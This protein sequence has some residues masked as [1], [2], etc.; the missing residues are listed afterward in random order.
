MSN[1]FSLQGRVALITGSSRGLGA[2]MAL[3]LAQAGAHVVLN[4]RNRE[5]LQA[6][7]KEITDAGGQASIA[8]FDVCQRTDADAA[9]DAI[10]DTHGHLDILINNAV[11]SASGDFLDTS[12]E[13]WRRTLDSALDACFRLSRKAAAGMVARGWGRIVMISSV[14]ARI[15]RGTNTAYIT[16]KAGL[17]GLTRGMAVELAA[18]GVTVNAIAPGYM[19]TDINTTFRADPARYE[20]IRNRTPMKRWGTPQDLA[21]AAVFLASDAS[22]FITG[23]TLVADGG[24]T[25]AI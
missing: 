23:Q 12:D 5:L 22:A 10:T 2:G 18:K 19:A 14:N 6:R 21:G 16:A 13:D 4:G 15:S 20:W 1:P 17:E 3:G 8:A 9:I 25:I 24:M 7:Q 11:S